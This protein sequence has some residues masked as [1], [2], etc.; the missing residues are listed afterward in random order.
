MTSSGLRGR[1]LALSLGLASFWILGL[2]CTQDTA[3]DGTGGNLESAPFELPA[4]FGWP[5]VLQP[6]WNFG[7]IH[8]LVPVLQSDKA[9]PLP[10]LGLLL[11]LH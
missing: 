7:D 3:L 1:R 2:S 10:I 6:C 5:P 9:H 8:A 11:E 4:L